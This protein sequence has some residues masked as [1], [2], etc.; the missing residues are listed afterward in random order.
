[1]VWLGLLRVGQ[2]CYCLAG[3]VKG[4][5]GLILLWFGWG[6][7]GLAEVVIV[8]FGCGCY[9]LAGVDEGWPGVVKGELQTKYMKYT[10]SELL[11]INVSCLA[12]MVIRK[13]SSKCK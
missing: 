5:L 12:T 10:F 13:T 8:W 11:V 3:V 1:M 9:G 2:G 6:C 7:Y 4:W